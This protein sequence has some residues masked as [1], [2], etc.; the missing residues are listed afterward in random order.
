MKIF[1]AC[2]LLSFSSIVSALEPIVF[3]VVHL[4]VMRRNVS[5]NVSNALICS[6][7]GWKKF[8]TNYP[9][10]YMDYPGISVVTLSDTVTDEVTGVFINNGAL[11]VDFAESITQGSDLKLGQLPLDI[12]NTMISVV[13]LKHSCDFSTI[14]VRQSVNP[15]RNVKY[16]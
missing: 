3:E 8:L 15:A 6:E 12:K 2:L 13:T 9:L 7:R 16:E 11:L 5:D 10:I 1:I 14:K 4:E